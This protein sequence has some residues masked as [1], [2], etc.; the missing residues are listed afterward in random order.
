MAEIPEF[1][2]FPR[3]VGRDLEVARAGAVRVNENETWAHRFY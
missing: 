2:V 3:C 1:D